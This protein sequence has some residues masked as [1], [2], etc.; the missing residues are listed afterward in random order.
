MDCGKL[1]DLLSK[2]QNGKP[3]IDE[4]LGMEVFLKIK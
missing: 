3:G 2:I 4:Q 1:N